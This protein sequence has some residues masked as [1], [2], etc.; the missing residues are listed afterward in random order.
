M[1]PGPRPGGPA[2]PLAPDR[3]TFAEH[4]Q[5]IVPAML[6]LLGVNLVNIVNTQTGNKQNR[7]VTV[8]FRAARASN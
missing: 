6:V 4:D 1:R 7:L 5:S 2:C 8:P 3:A